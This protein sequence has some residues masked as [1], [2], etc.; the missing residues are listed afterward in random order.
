MDPFHTPYFCNQLQ[1]LQLIVGQPFALI[2]A[3][4]QKYHP[5]FDGYL[6]YALETFRV[7]GRVG[8]WVCVCVIIIT[9]FLPQIAKNTH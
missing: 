7:W 6:C 9:A 4:R 2:L 5:T 1:W 8:V 3:R